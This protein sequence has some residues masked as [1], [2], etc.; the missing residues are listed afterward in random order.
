[1]IN[2][3]I[4][5]PPEI[6]S[7]IEESYPLTDAYEYDIQKGLNLIQPIH[8]FEI[9]QNMYVNEE[10]KKLSRMIQK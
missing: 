2:E 7:L 3:K 5:N 9:I 1:M 4:A 6:L 8:L 10:K